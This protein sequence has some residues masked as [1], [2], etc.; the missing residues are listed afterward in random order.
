MLSLGEKFRD[1]LE[2]QLQK[3]LLGFESI[4]FFATPRRLAVLVLS[5]D[6]SQPPT[7]IERQGPSVTSAFDK[8]GTP[9]LACLG[10]ARSCGVSTEALTVKETPTGSWV[11]CQLTSPG[12]PTTHLLPELVEAAISGIPLTKPMR[13]G[14][15]ITPFVRPVHWVV[16]L[17]GSA[18]ISANFFDQPT[19][20][21]TLG[22]RFHHSG[23]LRIDNPANYASILEKQGNVI[24]DFSKRYTAIVQQIEDLSFP[25][26]PVVTDPALLHEVTGMV[27]W[28][29][30]LLGRFNKNFLTLPKEIL[31]TTLK[32]HQRCFSI[33]DPAHEGK[34]LPYFITIS[35]IESKNPKKVILGN[36]R[37]IHARLS[38][39]SFFYE[40][41]L[42]LPLGSYLPRLAEVG[43]HQNLSNLLDK[44]HRLVRLTED[45][46][47]QVQT[48]ATAVKRAALLS[49][50]DL[51]S[52][53]VYEFP[54]LQGVMGYYYARH[55]EESP[56]V[57]QAIAEHYYPR[58]SGD[59]L[60]QSVAGCLLGIA[61]R[62]DTIVGI[63]GI[64]QLPTG[65]KDP[66]GLRRAAIGILRVL[67]EKALNIDLRWLV[68]RAQSAYQQPLPNAEVGEEVLHFFNERLPSLYAEQDVEPNVV[69]A[70][71]SKK[72][73][74]PL[75]V[76]RRIRA[77]QQF[78]QLP[79]FETL[80]ST[81]KRINNLVKKQRI[82]KQE[83]KENLLEQSDEVKLFKKLTSVQKHFVGKY[84]AQDYLSALHHLV[85]LKNP[86]DNFFNT[87]LV[88]DKKVDIRTNRLVLLSQIN[89]LFGKVADLSLL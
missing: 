52:K 79:E 71:L 17:Y 7:V 49:K 63:I 48:D 87:I 9:T 59:T 86:I 15:H 89:D 81:Y 12:H 88:M 25:L 14:K 11:C 53:V 68:N 18:L 41:D 72:I 82:P 8:D 47:K 21:E 40:Q 39:A 6:V 29:V 36:E 54:S 66:F 61:D 55:D 51:L 31:I 50:C 57:A 56:A 1:S 84:E 30:A 77:L 43:F 69:E 45:L 67:I 70:V 76:D 60:P 35:N 23:K 19:S 73:F 62:I 34:L 24:S 26:G 3:Y 28:P 2:Q 85:A 65:D 20:Q 46:A 44:T 42:K 4:K 5:L 10:F 64:H 75:D 74:N 13:W 80:A 83:V 78:I 16:L 37:V 33:Q 27:E 58:F 32:T 22:H 38:D